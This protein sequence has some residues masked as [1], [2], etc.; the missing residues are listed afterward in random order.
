MTTAASRPYRMTRRADAAAATG[1]RILDAAIEVFWERP[2][3]R[4]SLGEVA[5]RAGV[6]KQ[7]VLRRFGSKAGLLA[8]A[9]E[10]ATERVD[11]ERGDVV[12]GDV[13][14]AIAALVEHYERIGDGV[15]RMLAE[16]ARSPGLRQVADRGRAYHAR[17]CE[18]V[19]A[20]AL[21][22]LGGAERDRRLAMLI[23]V[24]DV[25]TWR[26]LRR[27]RG[28]TRRQTET[29]LRELLEPVTGGR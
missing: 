6:A 17:W 26:L 21:G 1:E 7:T 23:A 3:D 11:A 15:L 5:R 4:L 27:D 2:T 28:L 18:R 12:A 19:F 25:H 10:R 24:T 13:P 16:E 14:G 9:V 22:G 20:A 8:A 29:A